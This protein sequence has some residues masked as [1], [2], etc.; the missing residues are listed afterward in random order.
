MLHYRDH[1]GFIILKLKARLKIYIEITRFKQA[2]IR[3]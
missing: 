1:I 3:Y 2:I